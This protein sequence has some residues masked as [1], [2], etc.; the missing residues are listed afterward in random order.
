MAYLLDI[1]EVDIDV[2]YGQHPSSTEVGSGV[3]SSVQGGDVEMGTP[4]LEDRVEISGGVDG[5]D[6][7]QD[8]AETVG[9]MGWT[10]NRDQ[11]TPVS[12]YSP[13]PEVPMV[14]SPEPENAPQTLKILYVPDPSRSR[15][16]QQHAQ[17]DLG[18]TD[19]TIL[20]STFTTLRSVIPNYIFP[21]RGG[22]LQNRHPS[23][24]K[25]TKVRIS[26]WVCAYLH[27]FVAR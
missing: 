9:T 16:S 2:I 27:T 6:D 3:G 21:R 20:K 10:Y 11:S 19:R 7:M 13:L 14:R 15:D 4:E 22:G 5:T 12:R 25:R 8:I 24:E 1:P 18:F 26:E 17:A 23:E